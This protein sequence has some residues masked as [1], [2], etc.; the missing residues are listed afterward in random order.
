MS[1]LGLA[2]GVLVP[3][4]GLAFAI[5]K[6]GARTVFGRIGDTA[7]RV[8]TKAWIALAILAVLIGGYF[9]HQHRAHVALSAA[10]A[11]GSS[12]RDKAWQ[13]RLDAEHAE[14]VK[15]KAKAESEQA[16]ISNDIGARHAQDLR[17]IDAR[18]DEQR[19]RGPGQAAAP[20]CVRSG[21]HS[22]LPP[23]PGGHVAPGGAGD[24]TVAGLPQ[25]E[26]LAI[27]PWNPLVAFGADHDTDRAEVMAWREWYTRQA[28][29]NRK[30]RGADPK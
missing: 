15:W 3:G 4:G 24:A 30:E 2:L 8:P 16:S 9:L 14:A 7:R 27:V 28:E 21:D 29:L 5:A 18:A 6:F 12:D 19:L 23:G 13:K 1:I 10:Y 25:G 11:A 20:A 17:H 22:S 26:P